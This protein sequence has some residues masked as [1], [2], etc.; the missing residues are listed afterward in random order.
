ML[1]VALAGLFA[2][3]GLSDH[4]VRGHLGTDPM[5]MSPAHHSSTATSSVT[6][7][8]SAVTGDGTSHQGA[9][10]C[11]AVIGA[12]LLLLLATGRRLRLRGLRA[13]DRVLACRPGTSRARSPDPPDLHLLSIQ[14]C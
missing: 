5:A 13:F 2:M 12:G 9:A 10:L 14:R 3:H 1:L 6:G 11:L 4:G 8:V 7:S